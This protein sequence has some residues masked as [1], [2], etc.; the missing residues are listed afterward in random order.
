[1]YKNTDEELPDREERKQNVYSVVM[2]QSEDKENG[3]DNANEN[4]NGEATTHL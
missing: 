3:I 1:M 4:E 2:T